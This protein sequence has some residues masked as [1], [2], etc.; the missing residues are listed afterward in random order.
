MFAGSLAAGAYLA[1]LSLLI[2]CILVLM[3]FLLGLLREVPSKYGL[4]VISGLAF[5]AGIASYLGWATP[6]LM[7]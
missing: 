7:Y 2:L 4:A 1:T 6:A 3:A 5:G